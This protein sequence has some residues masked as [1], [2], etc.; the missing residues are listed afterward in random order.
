MKRS[1]APSLVP[2]AVTLC[3]LSATPAVAE[4]IDPANDGSQYAYVEN[5]GWLDTEPNGDGREGIQVGDDELS[6]W[7]WGENV[8]WLSL[9]CAGTR[10]GQH[11]DCR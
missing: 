3:L 6:G 4:N 9:S 10:G 1:R 11:S 8:G 7:M 2:V 5:A